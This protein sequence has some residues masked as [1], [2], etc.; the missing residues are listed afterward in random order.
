MKRPKLTVTV[1]GPPLSRKVLLEM[2]QEL[3]YTVQK[4]SL[5]HSEK[6]LLEVLAPYG[7]V[8]R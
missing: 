3:G 1:E 5:V 2:I 6:I 4:L 7:E 8:G